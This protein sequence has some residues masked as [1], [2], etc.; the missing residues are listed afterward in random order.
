MGEKTSQLSTV[1]T[2]SNL[3][4]TAVRFGV[5]TD[6]TGTPGDAG[7]DLS[8]IRQHLSGLTPVGVFTSTQ[9]T[10]VENTCVITNST[11]A[12][13]NVAMPTSPSNFAR[14]ALCDP[15]DQWGT[16]PV[17]LLY[18]S[19]VSIE[20]N[21]A[22]YLLNISG[23][24]VEFMN[25]PTLGWKL[26]RTASVSGLVPDIVSSAGPNLLRGTLSILESGT[27]GTVTLPTANLPNYGIV[28]NRSGGAL[29]HARAG[30]DTLNGGTSAVSVG[31][32]AVAVYATAG[33]G[34]TQMLVAGA[35]GSGD[36]TAAS[37]FGTDNKIIRADGTSKG[38][39]SSPIIIPDHTSN[40]TLDV[41]NLTSARTLKTPDAAGTIATF[42]QIGI[43]NNGFTIPTGEVVPQGEILNLGGSWHGGV[44]FT[45]VLF[46]FKFPTNL[47]GITAVGLL[48]TTASASQYAVV[49]IYERS[50][51]STVGTNVFRSS[52]IDCSSTG[53]SSVSQ[54]LTIDHSKRY[55]CGIA[56][57]YAWVDF[58]AVAPLNSTQIRV[59]SSGDMAPMYIRQTK[60]DLAS[61]LPTTW[62][63]GSLSSSSWTNATSYQV[64]V[65]M[66][67][68]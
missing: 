21:A 16:N 50:G 67:A 55:W 57:G 58:R 46:P 59:L 29:N 31:D 30:T 1:L 51:F 6:P 23:R 34:D 14:F 41:T 45:E 12:G 40:L 4:T 54:S 33:D 28:L 64:A 37:T 68:A 61:C 36:V 60:S 62:D 65:F 3:L 56:T 63:G 22:N 5:T 27:S 47:T 10:S 25:I 2:T 39:Q 8:V 53:L 52:N 35:G 26:I 19:A 15:Y 17:T 48:I 38:V 13:F 66:T 24:Y 42:D 9:A 7:L 32:G 49:A 44:N 11:S 43:V 20:G 18:D